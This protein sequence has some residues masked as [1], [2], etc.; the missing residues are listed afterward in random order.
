MEKRFFLG[1][2]VLGLVLLGCEA[3]MVIAKGRNKIST[4]ETVKADSLDIMD[5]KRSTEREFSLVKSVK[6][7]KVDSLQN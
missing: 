2:C 7:V 3:T 1:L 5:R 4:S 6:E